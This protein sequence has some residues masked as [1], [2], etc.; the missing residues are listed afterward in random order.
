MTSP[1]VA[2]TTASASSRFLA[3]HA[4][5]EDHSVVG[6]PER[7]V[8][9]PA[10]TED[11]EGQP[12]EHLSAGRHDQQAALGSPGVRVPHLQYGDVPC[13]SERGASQRSLARRDRPDVGPAHRPETKV[14]RVERIG[15]D[16]DLAGVCPDELAALPSQVVRLD[17]T[18]LRHDVEHPVAELR[19]LMGQRLAPRSGYKEPLPGAGHAMSELALRQ[20]SEG[21]SCRSLRTLC[22]SLAASRESGGVTD[23]PDGSRVAIGRS[24]AS[25]LGSAHTAPH[26]PS[27]NGGQTRVR[28]PSKFWPASPDRPPEREWN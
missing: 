4:A 23:Q 26:D 24:P 12:P 18:E 28:H 21:G 8:G 15:L 20:P 1:V 16:R 9:E 7:G 10:S 22:C 17:R 27:D 3:T 6:V 13:R 5:A 19:E 2:S 25:F 11:V 14:G